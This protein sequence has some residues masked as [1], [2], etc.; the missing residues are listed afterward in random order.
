MEGDGRVTSGTDK[1]EASV[2]SEIR[3]VGPHRLLLLSHICLVLVIDEIND[4]G[5]RVAV[6]DVV[7]ETRSV[8]NGELSFE[9]L[10]FELCLDDFDLCQLVKLFEVTAVI[11]L[12]GRQLGGE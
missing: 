10:L 1:V 9:L 7:A 6:V 12:W 8:N 4:G 3:L 11:V 5:P 2:H